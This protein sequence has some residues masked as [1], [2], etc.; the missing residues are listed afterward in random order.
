MSAFTL[1]VTSKPR[2]TLPCI[3]VDSPQRSAIPIGAQLPSP[4][5]GHVSLT[6]CA[7]SPSSL[8]YDKFMLSHVYAYVNGYVRYP[9]YWPYEWVNANTSCRGER[10]EGSAPRKPHWRPSSLSVQERPYPHRRYSHPSSRQGIQQDGICRSRWSHT[11]DSEQL[12]WLPAIDWNRWRSPEHVTPSLP[13]RQ[14]RGS[15]RALR[16]Q[17]CAKCGWRVVNRPPPAR[18]RSGRWIIK[19]TLVVF[20]WS[21]TARYW[22]LMST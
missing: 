16:T 12:Y 11:P 10:H 3:S 13:S 18:L 20:G 21:R 1:G 8:V 5:G 6:A 14:E 7:Y 15:Q 4:R 9:A 19:S 17:Q 2:G 22:V